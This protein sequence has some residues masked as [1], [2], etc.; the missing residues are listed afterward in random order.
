MDVPEILGYVASFLDSVGV[1]PYLT[2]AV[3]VSLAIS[4]VKR[5]FE[6]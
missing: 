5:F 3:I 4:A 2:A 6:N 1:M